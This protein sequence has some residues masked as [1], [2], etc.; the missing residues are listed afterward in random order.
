MATKMA[1]KMANIISIKQNLNKY[2]LWH[3][4]IGVDRWD[5]D[6]KESINWCKLYFAMSSLL[7]C[8]FNMAAKLKMAIIVSNNEYLYI[9]WPQYG[10]QNGY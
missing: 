6:S 10:H 7:Q 9:L 4:D 8:K 5:F 1:T 3:Y 2:W